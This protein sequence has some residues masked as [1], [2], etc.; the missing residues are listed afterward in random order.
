MATF[1]HPSRQ[2]RLPLPG[3]RRQPEPYT[4][5]VGRRLDEAPEVY[6]VKDRDVQRLHGG[7]R[8]APLALDWRAEDAR[9]LELSHSLLTI[10]ARATPPRELAEQFASD[11]LSR[12]PEDGFVLES[13]WVRGWLQ[14]AWEPIE[15]S[16]TEPGRRS[17][18]GRLTAPLRRTGKSS[19]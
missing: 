6:V 17:W 4:Y 8:H 16:R 19:A 1:E 9:S 14:Q 18:L 7:R 12:L 15:A 3:R 10:V 5:F 11:V 13:W 2:R